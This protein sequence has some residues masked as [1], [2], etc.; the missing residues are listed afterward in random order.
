MIRVDDYKF[1]LPDVRAGHTEIDWSNI[2]NRLRMYKLSVVYTIWTVFE[3]E[4]WAKMPRA[5]DKL[6]GVTK[7]VIRCR[8]NGGNETSGQKGFFEGAHTR[9]GVPV[10]KLDAIFSAIKV[11]EFQKRKVELP[12]V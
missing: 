8:T 3:T 6:K 2:N 7:A 4:I 11:P 12:V 1:M 10:D 5:D 9:N